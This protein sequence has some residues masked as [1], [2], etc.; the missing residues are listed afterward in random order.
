MTQTIKGAL[1][2]FNFSFSSRLTN[3]GGFEKEKFYG[4]YLVFSSVLCYQLAFFIFY[5]HILLFSISIFFSA[6]LED[7][8]FFVRARK[9]YSLASFGLWKGLCGLQMCMLLGWL[10]LIPKSSV[11]FPS[12]SFKFNEVFCIFYIRRNSHYSTITIF[13]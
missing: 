13:Q 8:L 1:H 7:F 10:I 9:A 6:G 3:Y 11:I 5:R 4:F 2:R 12:F